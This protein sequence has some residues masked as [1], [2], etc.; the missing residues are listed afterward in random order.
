MISRHENLASSMRQGLAVGWRVMML[1]CCVWLQAGHASAQGTLVVTSSFDGQTPAVPGTP[2]ELRLSRELGANE[3]RIAITIDRTDVTSLF[4][5]DGPRFVYSPSLVPLPLGESHVIV[6]LVSDDNGWHEIARYVLRVVK[7]RPAEP[8]APTSVSGPVAGNDPVAATQVNSNGN[9]GASA[10]APKANTKAEAASQTRG[11]FGFDKAEYVPS[12]TLALKS[13]PAQ[14]NFPADTRPTERATFTDGTLQFSMRNQMTRGWFAAETSFDFA[15]STFHPEALRFGTLGTEAPQIDL[16]SY[17]VQ[18]KLGRAKVAIGHT[19]FGSSRHLISGFSSRGI[20]VTVP[21]TKRFDVGAAVLN[22]TNVVGYGNLLGLAKSKHQLH[23]ATLGVELLPNRPGGLRLE[24]SAINAYIQALNS[25]SQ[26]SVNDVERSKGGSIR[27]IATDKAGRLK[28]EGGFTRSQY[29]NPADPLL[30]QG[31]NTLA[32]PFLTRNARYLDI[33]Y[34]VLRG[35]SLTKNRQVSLSLSVRHERVDPLYKS[36]GASA[37]A[38]KSQNDFQLLG[39]IGEISIQ[40]SHG[41]FNDNLRG[42]PSILKSLTRSNQF[43]VAL[44]AAALWG[45]TSDTS[46]YLPRVSYSWSKTHQFG[47]AI[48]VNGGFENDPAAVPNQFSI[49]QNFS[50]DWQINKLNL[51]YNYNRS[52]TNNQQRG[53]EQSDFLNQTT[54]LR[55]GFN[56]TSKLNLNFD[57]TRDSA[58]DLESAKLARTWRAGPTMSWTFNKHITWTAGLSNTIA[59][60]RAETNSSRNTE[61][62]TQ[63]SYNRGVDRG[64]LK[65]VQT[66]LFIRYADRYA[67]SHD[68]VFQTSNLTRVK[69]VNAGVNITFF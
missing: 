22:G 38:D 6:Y 47:A 5:V 39:S 54:G 26:G 35:Y 27:L 12:L 36:L 31:T 29:R 19:S 10:P 2:I 60:D 51:G 17:L 30:Y 21:I 37:G 24:F 67:R 11:R 9:G 41:R 50:A 40:A 57:L 66:Q 15:G 4:I 64:E 65:K 56:P 46:K 55:V 20:T 18:L 61:F 42:I 68:L 59:G 32:V 43:S 62:D 25:F 33:S 14:S 49:S 3:G 53:R 52:L 44:P 16:S 45:G 23:S 48:P 58:N 63:F 7:E 1:T 28:F 69:I 8:V 34:D 13:Q